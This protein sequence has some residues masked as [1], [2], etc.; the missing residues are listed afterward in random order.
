MVIFMASVHEVSP[1]NSCPHCSTRNSSVGE[2]KVPGR[3]GSS[4]R[5]YLRSCEGKKTEGIVSVLV[6]SEG[7]SE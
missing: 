5:T 7:K 3:L 6:E 1:V 2:R 4:M